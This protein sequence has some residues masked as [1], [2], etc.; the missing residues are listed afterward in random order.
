LIAGVG[1]KEVEERFVLQKD[2][3]RGVLVV[4]GLQ[5]FEGFKRVAGAGVGTDVA[6]SHDIRAGGRTPLSIRNEDAPYLAFLAS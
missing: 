5:E 6:H 3:A 4:S 1:V 2:K